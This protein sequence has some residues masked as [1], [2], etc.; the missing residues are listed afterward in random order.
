MVLYERMM[1][2][3]LPEQHR[4][5]VV[6]KRNGPTVHCLLLPIRVH[7]CLFVSV[8]VIV[9]LMRSASVQCCFVGRAR[10]SHVAVR[11]FLLLTTKS[12]VSPV[13]PLSPLRFRNLARKTFGVVAAVAECDS[14]IV[15]TDDS[16][17]Q[18]MLP[19]G[20]PQ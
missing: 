18:G 9:S 19:M 3:W 17:Q 6:S 11:K 10:S 5:R 2:V 20:G 14:L 1:Y 12:R 16:A 13:R 4:V 7:I 8:I 15:D